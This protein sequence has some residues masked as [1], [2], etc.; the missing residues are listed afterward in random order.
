MKKTLKLNTNTETEDRLRIAE[1]SL[2]TQRLEA[3]QDSMEAHA[4]QLQHFSNSLFKLH[5]GSYFNHLWV[6]VYSISIPNLLPFVLVVLLYVYSVLVFPLYPRGLS[7]SKMTEVMWVCA[8]VKP[9]ERERLR[10]RKK[11]T[12]AK[13]ANEVERYNK[14]VDL[15]AKLLEAR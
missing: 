2:C 4:R 9:K 15:K 1:E 3:L 6:S 12:E 13:L 8:S 14:L 11:E 10:K 7:T 5:G